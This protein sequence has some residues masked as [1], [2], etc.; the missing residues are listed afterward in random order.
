MGD[1]DSLLV[2][3]SLRRAR[4]AWRRILNA[5]L[6]LRPP[7]AVVDAGKKLLLD[8]VGELQ[9]DRIVVFALL[10]ANVARIG[11]RR[12]FGRVG[13]AGLVGGIVVGGQ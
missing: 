9:T 13:I 1:L 10:L 6:L 11:P 7:R 5:N 12:T 3:E 2:D 4:T 8:I